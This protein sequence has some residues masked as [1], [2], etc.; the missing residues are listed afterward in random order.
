[1]NKEET[2]AE[3]VQ[4]YQNDSLV[5]VRGVAKK[6]KL[7][8]TTL[9]RHIN[10]LYR[11][12]KPGPL[13]IFTEREE[14]SLMLWIEPHVD[15][16]LS[17][18]DID[19][20]RK[21]NQLL[22]SKRE[23]EAEELPASVG[24]AWLEGFYDRHLILTKKKGEPTDPQ[25]F[26]LSKEKLTNWFSML[27]QVIDD[28]HILHDRILNA[29]EML[30]GKST[31]DLQPLDKVVFAVFKKK[32]RDAI[33]TSDPTSIKDKWSVIDLMKLASDVL[34]QSVTPSL[35]QS[36]FLHTGIE[37]FNA[38]EIITKMFD[39]PSVRA[40]VCDETLRT[41]LAPTFVTVSWKDPYQC[42]RH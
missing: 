35:I 6:Y 36:A 18:R 3:A 32:Y 19:L 26:M 39:R 4:E 40:S 17:L 41:V 1:M 37:L 31:A 33:Y 20:V 22:A 12:C 9:G 29:N 38:E 30:P 21:A 10:N 16:G 5:P 15:F 8:H 28:A 2:I 14:D 25:R 23:T 13:P 11:R 34:E 24:Q 42:N 7:D 27:K